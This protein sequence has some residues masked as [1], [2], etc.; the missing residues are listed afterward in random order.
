MLDGLVSTHPIR[1]WSN[2]FEAMLR[3][4]SQAAWLSQPGGINNDPTIWLDGAGPPPSYQISNYM[5]L[6]NQKI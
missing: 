6:M 2:R 5:S 3:S 1:S 4:F